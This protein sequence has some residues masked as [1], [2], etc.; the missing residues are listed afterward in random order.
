MSDDVRLKLGLALTQ[1]EALRIIRK[2]ISRLDEPHLKLLLGELGELIGA[3]VNYSTAEENFLFRL[4]K[5]LRALPGDA[6]EPAVLDGDVPEPPP[7]LPI[8]QRG[9]HGPPQLSAVAS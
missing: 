2:I 6:A 9:K 4:V 8:R 5:G 1:D 7:P 3:E